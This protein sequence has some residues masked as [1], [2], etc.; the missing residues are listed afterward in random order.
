LVREAPDG[1]KVTNFQEISQEQDIFAK[2]Y[3]IANCYYFPRRLCGM[4]DG[5]TLSVRTCQRLLDERC[6]AS[7]QTCNSN[8]RMRIVW[9]SNYSPI[10]ST[11]H[12]LHLWDYDGGN[13]V[14]A[15]KLLGPL[16]YGI[17]DSNHLY[18]V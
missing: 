1:P 16:A 5:F 18:L 17:N 4:H 15:R 9:R 2:T 12:V 3:H 7:F 6:H 8:T 10:D 13:A 14:P 11:K